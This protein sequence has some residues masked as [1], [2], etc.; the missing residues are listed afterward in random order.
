LRRV[1]RLVGWFIVVDVLITLGGEALAPL[2]LCLAADGLVGLLIMRSCME[3]RAAMVA[4]PARKEPSSPMAFRRFKAA[5]RRLYA[6]G[7]H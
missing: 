3:M 5:S 2:L 6:N 7:G 4:A 1:G